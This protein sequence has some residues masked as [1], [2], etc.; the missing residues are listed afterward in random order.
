[1]MKNHVS[2]DFAILPDEELRSIYVKAK[3]KQRF[4]SL[5]ML[6]SGVI[7]IYSVAALALSL[8]GAVKDLA[9]PELPQ[10]SSELCLLFGAAA[11]FVGSSAVFTENSSL[12][13][14]IFVFSVIFE[15]LAIIG[16]LTLSNNEGFAMFLLLPQLT[17]A[18]LS[19]IFVRPVI[20]LL[21]ELKAHPRFPF[22]NTVYDDSYIYKASD[23]NKLDIIGHS[24]DPK[25]VRSIGGDEF[26]E[27]DKKTFETPEPDPVDNLQQHKTVW[28][29]RD[30][31]ETAYTMDNLKNMYFDDGRKNG[32]LTGEELEKLL[33]EEIRPKKPKEKEPEDFLQQSPIIWRTNKDGSTTL[34]RREPGAV[35]AGENDSRSVLM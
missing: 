29:P 3:K 7:L 35:P 11:G 22:K 17:A 10:N 31:N 32:E 33:W 18:V 5:Q 20:K 12:H 25:A 19:N 21:E 30:K 15:L 13:L 34:D 23:K 4:L 1:M 16:L 27:G 9:H 14:R 24:I 28:R 2:D 6:L 26:L 8:L